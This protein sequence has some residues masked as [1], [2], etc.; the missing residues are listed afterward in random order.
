MNDIKV[1]RY[2]KGDEKEICDIVKKD[3][4]AENVKDYSKEY[5]E[6]LIHTHNEI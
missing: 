4:L 2:I 5:I 3:V 1:R 6:H